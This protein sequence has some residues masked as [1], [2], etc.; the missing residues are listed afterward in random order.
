MLSSGA[1]KGEALDHLIAT[2]VLR[3]GKATGRYDTD[4][5][6]VDKPGADLNALW[7][8]LSI[9]EDATQSAKLPTNEL[10]R[11][12]GPLTVWFDRITQKAIASLPLTFS[13]L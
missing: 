9:N 7:K 4:R 3:T 8:S 2:K 6:D 11:K 10:K 12:M 5:E 13:L 1:S